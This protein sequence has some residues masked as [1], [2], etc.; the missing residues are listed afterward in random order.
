MVAAMKTSPPSKTV[1]PAGDPSGP[2]ALFHR[3]PENVGAVCT[4]SG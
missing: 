3:V 4:L 2:V 1:H